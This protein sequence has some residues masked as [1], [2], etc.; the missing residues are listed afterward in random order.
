MPGPG[1]AILSLQTEIL[2]RRVT[3]VV[4]GKV[5]LPIKKAI[6]GLMFVQP[7]EQIA[8]LVQGRKRLVEPGDQVAFGGRSALEEQEYK[9]YN[10]SP[11]TEE[12]V[13]EY[14]RKG[15]IKSTKTKPKWISFLN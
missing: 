9:D 2:E 5:L 4:P 3:A 1:T 8:Q 13:E 7:D 6:T 10:D 11:F 12:L 15:I 14:R